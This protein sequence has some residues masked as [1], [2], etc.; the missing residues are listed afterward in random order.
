MT[1]QLTINFFHRHYTKFDRDKLF[2][3]K[4][5]IILLFLQ[6]YIK[7][8]KHLWWGVLLMLFLIAE[9]NFTKKKFL[10]QTFSSNSSKIDYQWNITTYFTRP[11]GLTSAILYTNPLKFHLSRRL[12]P[13]SR[14]NLALLPDDC[15]N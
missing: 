12:V 7:K 3:G 5:S 10:L 8:G 2:L 11:H 4:S 14:Y 15:N 1:N 13:V 6:N 9:C